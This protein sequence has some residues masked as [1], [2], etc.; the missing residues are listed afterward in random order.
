M[1]GVE[2]EAGLG[3]AAYAERDWGTAYAHLAVAG[4]LCH[5]DL[6]RLA[7]AAYLTGH[8]AEAATA[9]MRAHHSALR[10]GDP[11]AAARTAFWLGL[12]LILRGRTVQGGGWLARAD[13]LLGAAGDCVER[14]YLLIPAGLSA[15][16]GDAAAD[17]RGR[18]D[19]AAR[20]AERHA[21]PDLLALARLGLGQ[22]AIR[23]G[24]YAAGRRLLDE[25]MVAVT[26]DEVSAVVAGIVY[27]AVIEACHELHDLDRAQEWTAALSEWCEGQPSLVPYRGQCLVHR[28]EVLRRSGSWAD[29]FELARRAQER[30]GG[31]AEQPALGAALYEIAEL[32]RLRGDRAA[33]ERYYRRASTWIGEPQPGLALLR[34][35]QGRVD[36]AAAAMRRLLPSIG[37]DTER[38]RLLAPYV[39]IMLAAGDVPAARAAADELRRIAGDIGSRWLAAA[40]HHQHGSVLLAEGS[41]D[42][43]LA[44]LRT[45]WAA[46][47]D[48]GTPYEAARARLHLGLACAAAGDDDAA[49][50]EFEAA[51]Q[52]LAGLGAAPD[53]DRARRLREAARARGVRG[54]LTARETQVL[55][56]VAAGR[57]NR[58]IGAE[59]RLSSK[60]VDRHVSNIFAK[61]GVSS[62]AAAT[63]RAYERDLV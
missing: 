22:T 52:A 39:E 17:A 28:A 44:E 61:L 35:A 46:W 31:P 4:P 3:K 12:H 13:R 26:A 5:Q 45:A 1:G 41:T 51:H 62:R 29:A 63:A 37:H 58:A 20:I 56:L 21:D 54:D 47:R 16:A 42:A 6:E 40:A 57:T 24:E 60:T 34:M 59:L 55:R 7:A 10:D 23:G 38:C 33:A 25:A 18:F 50:A 27:C 8:D 15:L 2:H 11:R 48:L 30:L 9:L 49:C 43:A 32:H 19:E 14:G 36:A 53:A